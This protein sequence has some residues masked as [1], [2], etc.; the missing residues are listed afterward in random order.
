MFLAL[1]SSY[2]LMAI[3]TVISLL[4]VPLLVFWLGDE[5]YGLWLLAGAVLSHLNLGSFG[6][7]GSI[8]RRLAETRGT[9]DLEQR[10]IVASS[11]FGVSLVLSSLLMIGGIVLAAI[12]PV[13]LPDNATVEQS[14]LLRLIIFLM[15]FRMASGVALQIFSSL[16]FTHREVPRLH[17][18]KIVMNIV[19]FLLGLGVILTGGGLVEYAWSQVTGFLIQPLVCY[20]YTRRVL[21]PTGLS[22]SRIRRHEAISLINTGGWLVGLTALNLVLQQVPFFLISKNAGLA[23]V[24]ILGVNWKLWDLGRSLILRLAFVAWPR[25][26]EHAGSGDHAALLRQVKTIGLPSLLLASAGCGAMVWYVE[27]LIGWWINPTLYGGDALTIALGFLA[28]IKV[29]RYT[30]HMIILGGG[31]VDRLVKLGIPEALLLLAM[32]WPATT[33]GGVT[34]AA[35]AMVI[36]AVATTAWSWPCLV[37]D[38]IEVPRAKILG[39]ALVVQACSA[40]PASALSYTITHVWDVRNLAVI[41]LLGGVATCLG[42]LTAWLLALTPTDRQLLRDPVLRLLRR[43]SK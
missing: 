9:G 22:I 24:T 33:L 36:A 23:A 3:T 10:A 29:G 11:G 25:V 30:A 15:A 7:Q 4:M 18:A 28:L 41:C 26:S 34:G 32:L 37:A 6:L 16:L 2:I 43:Q 42:L 5:N 39:R 8:E 1:T 12:A 13:F 35:W 20:I 38:L 14:Y 31:Q 40:V 19:K 27:P 17:V 21:G